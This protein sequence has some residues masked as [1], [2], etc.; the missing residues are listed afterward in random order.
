MPDSSPRIGTSKKLS[1]V[2]VTLTEHSPGQER[3]IKV[4][5]SFSFKVSNEELPFRETFFC[6]FLFLLCSVLFQRDLK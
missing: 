5:K 3:L 1:A 6:L 4:S 2:A